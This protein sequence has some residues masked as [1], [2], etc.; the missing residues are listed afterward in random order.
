ME[1]IELSGK[2]LQGHGRYR[3]KRLIGY[4]ARGQVWEAWHN[5]LGRLLA[6]KVIDVSSLD[7]IDLERVKR[8]CSIGGELGEE[9]GIVRVHDAFEEQGNFY[10]VMDLMDG[11]N[12]QKIIKE[13]IPNLQ[14]TIGWASILADALLKVHKHKIIH[15]DIKPQNILFTRTGQPRIS[16]FGIAHIP[17]SS[18]TETQPGTLGYKAPELERGG[19]PSFASDVYSLGATL[20]EVWGNQPFVLYKS[21]TLDVLQ[22]E[23]IVLMEQAYPDTS[24]QLRRE[25]A[26]ILVRSLRSCTIA[27]N[28][29]R[30]I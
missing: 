26:S 3:I 6:I 22:E 20:F 15:R 19:E 24:L 28:W 7:P 23:L 13:K 21:Q 4:G 29:F 1:Y 25:L 18:F 16:D 5:F 8:E 10:I 11:G 12:L 2:I 9:T 17:T 30:I 14:T 27:S